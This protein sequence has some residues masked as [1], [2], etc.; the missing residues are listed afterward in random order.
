MHPARQVK[1]KRYEAQRS[2]ASSQA[3]QFSFN[4]ICDSRIIIHPKT[5]LNFFVCSAVLA[6]IDRRRQFPQRT[7]E[8]NATERY[9]SPSHAVWLAMRKLFRSST[10]ALQDLCP[11]QPAPTAT[12]KLSSASASKVASLPALLLRRR[13]GSNDVAVDA[14]LAA[15]KRDSEVEESQS[16]LAISA[17][18]ARCRSAFELKSSNNA[19][20]VK[21]TLG[22]RPCQFLASTSSAAHL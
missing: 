18:G 11:A 15:E 14:E 1:D 9:Q 16:G 3:T 2:L 7:S 19:R 5:S 17:S 8:L 22:E 10:R 13:L 21:D 20:F 4:P 6:P 12:H